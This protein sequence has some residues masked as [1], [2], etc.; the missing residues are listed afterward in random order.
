MKGECSSSNTVALKAVSSGSNTEE[1]MQT[2]T[3]NTRAVKQVFS[4]GA[5]KSQHIC[6]AHIS[7]KHNASID[8]FYWI[9]IRK[10]QKK[11]DIWVHAENRQRVV[12]LVSEHN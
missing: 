12:R 10:K 11:N 8:S 4:E 9:L 5:G 6:Y 7:T 1:D 2:I 3:A